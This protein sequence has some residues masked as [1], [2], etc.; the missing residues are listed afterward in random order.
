MPSRP[1]H[2]TFPFSYA[3]VKKSAQDG[4]EDCHILQ[5]AIDLTT[6]QDSAELCQ[7]NLNTLKEGRPALLLLGDQR[8]E[9]FS[10][11]GRLY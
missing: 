4:C 3:K 7:I 1:N 5:Q 10:Q 6:P 9:L 8:V 11:C 2:P